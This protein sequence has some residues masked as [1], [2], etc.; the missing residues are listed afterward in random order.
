MIISKD[1]KMV[2]IVLNTLLD[3]FQYVESTSG[4]S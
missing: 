4:V 1:D 2:F 3:V